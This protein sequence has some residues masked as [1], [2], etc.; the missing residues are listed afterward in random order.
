MSEP[1]SEL[2]LREHVLVD[3]IQADATSLRRSNQA[4]DNLRKA[5]ADGQLDVLVPQRDQAIKDRDAALADKDRATQRSAALKAR[6]DRSEDEKKTAVHMRD[7]F[8][9]QRDSSYSL[10]AKLDRKV[11]H[12]TRRYVFTLLQRRQTKLT[13]RFRQLIDWRVMD[14]SKPA[15]PLMAEDPTATDLVNVGAAP[16]P[17]GR[18]IFPAAVHA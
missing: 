18:L 5:T 13:Y 8:R 15:F 11:L 3:R 9:R 2:S 12:L 10:I 17:P 4:L 6:L 7:A 1:V 16:Y 14:K